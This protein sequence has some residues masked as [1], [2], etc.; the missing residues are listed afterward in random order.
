MWQEVQFL[1]LPGEAWQEI[2]LGPDDHDLVLP[3]GSP[4]ILTGQLK[5]QV[6]NF[7]QKRGG[8]KEWPK[9]KRSKDE[10]RPT[11]RQKG[12]HANAVKLH[13]LH[14]ETPVPEAAKNRAS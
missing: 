13:V 6:T 14:P 9:S 8:K 5:V 12:A 11:S 10:Q 7:G 1:G 2:F 4:L 3:M